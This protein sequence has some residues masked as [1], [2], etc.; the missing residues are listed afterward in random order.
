[1]DEALAFVE[2][3]EEGGWIEIANERF[4]PEREA[5][6]VINKDSDS[7]KRF[8][9]DYQYTDVTKVALVSDDDFDYFKNDIEPWLLMEAEEN[10]DGY[11]NQLPPEFA[12]AMDAVAP[13]KIVIAT[14]SLWDLLFLFFGVGTAFRVAQGGFQEN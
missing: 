1:M 11:D 4:A 13:W 7:I 10:S 9:I 3:V 12:A 8:M 5:Y 6:A 14:L 2:E